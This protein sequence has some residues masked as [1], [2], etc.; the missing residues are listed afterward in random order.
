[1]VTYLADAPADSGL[2]AIPGRAG[3]PWFG[4]TI[5]MMHGPLAWAT[6]RYERFGPV[7]WTRS[8]GRQV[9]V[10]LGPDAFDP[11]MTNRDRTFASGPQWNYF[12]GPFFRRGLMLLDADEHHYHKR[13]MVQAFTRTRLTSYLESMN[14]AIDAALADWT[15]SDRFAAYPALKRLTLDVATRTFMGGA[16]GAQADGINNAFVDCVRAG[17]AY[18]R[19]PVPGLRWARGL[20]AR[21]TLEDMLARQLPAKRA[22]TGTDLFTALCHAQSEDGDD[23]T[24]DDVVNHMIFLLMAAHDTTTITMS[25]MLYQ[26]AKHPEWQERCR[27]ESEA[28]GVADLS[29]GDLDSLVSLDLVMKES[30]RLVAPLPQIPR[31][32]VADCQVLGHFLPADTYV[33]VMP[34]FSH[35]MPELWTEPMRF[36]PERFGPGRHE[37]RSHKHAWVPFGAGVHKCIGQHFAGMQVKAVMHKL[38]RTFEFSAEPGYRLRLDHTSLPRPK[39][40]LILSLR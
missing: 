15:R 21:K 8:F 36:D 22:G 3:L 25:A 32:T 26:L 19:R 24:D 13:I 20:A 1:M 27:A 40:G 17:T 16:L 34:M 38:L 11:P 6:R 9:V 28:L 14:P 4:E 29:F 2:R 12:I 30:L 33:M 18:V 23:F 10:L 37:E 31:S 5:D 39:D 35:F 7:S